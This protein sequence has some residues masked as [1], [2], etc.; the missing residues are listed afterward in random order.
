MLRLL[1][2]ESP[3]EYLDQQGAR[4]AAGLTQAAQ[5]AG[6]T[7]QMQRVGSMMTLFFCS[8]PVYGWNEAS[9]CNRKLFA[10]YFWGLV[11]RGVYMP[12]SQFEALFFSRTHTPEMIEE[13]IAAAHEVLHELA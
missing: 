11:D 6:F 4:L 3:Y 2:D 10:A 13:T 5:S 9:T 8:Q 12:C 1:R 7:T